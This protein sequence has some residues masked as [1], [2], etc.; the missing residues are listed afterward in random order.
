VIVLD[1]NYFPSLKA[2]DIL[3]L[4]ERSFS[5]SVSASAIYEVRLF[6]F[7]EDVV[8]ARQFG[9]QFAGAEH[10]KLTKGSERGGRAAGVD[11]VNDFFVNQILQVSLRPPK[12]P[13]ADRRLVNR[14]R[15]ARFAKE[16]CISASVCGV[17][18]PTFV[19]RACPEG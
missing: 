9:E 8:V 5:V 13:G 1:S 19:G 16:G 10:E 18:L 17:A 6:E 15:P 14:Q 2:G 3:T 12:V 7:S 11:H 4:R